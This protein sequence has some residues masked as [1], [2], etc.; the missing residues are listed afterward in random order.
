[1][2]N[3]EINNGCLKTRGQGY[4]NVCLKQRGEVSPVVTM[5]SV[6]TSSALV[7]SNKWIRGEGVR[8]FPPNGVFVK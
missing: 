8:G 4:V 5:D 3:P 6:F 1:M 7:D 2:S